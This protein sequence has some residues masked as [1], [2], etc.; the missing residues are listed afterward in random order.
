M[1]GDFVMDKLKSF[2]EF[3]DSLTKDDIDYINETSSSFAGNLADPD[4]LKEF[5]GFVAGMNFGRMLRLLEVYHE[6]LQEQL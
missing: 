2:A 3:T 6:W 5:I 1:K 4:D